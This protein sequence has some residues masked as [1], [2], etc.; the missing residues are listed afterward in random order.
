[1]KKQKFLYVD[2]NDYF[3]CSE[4]NELLDEGYYVKKM[5]VIGKRNR[6]NCYVVLE[7]EITNSEEK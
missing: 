5:K 1:M 2:S 6:T 3:C 7:K 4:V